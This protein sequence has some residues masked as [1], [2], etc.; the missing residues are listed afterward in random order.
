MVLL[1]INR[2]SACAASAPA[3]WARRINRSRLFGHD[4]I[5]VKMGKAPAQRFES[6]DGGDHAASPRFGGKGDTVGDPCA[7][8]RSQKLVRLHGIRRN[9]RPRYVIR[10][11]GFDRLRQVTEQIELLHGTRAPM[12]TDDFSK[13][14][15]SSS[16][17]KPGRMSAMGTGLRQCDRILM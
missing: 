10:A 1:S 3:I 9:S 11:G 14:H 16:S 7:R 17:R 5:A 6:G 13:M 2:A 12:H 8:K 4:P 15:Q